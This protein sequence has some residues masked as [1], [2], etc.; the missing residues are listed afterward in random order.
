MPNRKSKSHKKQS[1]KHH[2]KSRLEN[3]TRSSRHIFKGGSSGSDIRQQLV[4][5]CKRGK[6]TEYDNLT[7][8]IMRDYSN[9][10]KNFFIHLNR[11]IKTFSRKTLSCLERSLTQ[12][13]EHAI[14]ESMPHLA[15]I[16]Q[17]RL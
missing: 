16:M 6:W 8:Q 12:L 15:Y 2:C 7:Q 4:I 9:N 1:W 10:K 3:H 11:N 17:Q 14:P 5:L 13:Q